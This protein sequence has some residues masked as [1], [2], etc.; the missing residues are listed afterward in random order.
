MID[1]GLPLKQLFESK[2]FMYEFDYDEWPSTHT[3][4]NNVLR[5]YHYSLLQVRQNYRNVFPEPEYKDEDLNE[6]QDSSKIF[7]IKYTINILPCFGSHIKL[8]KNRQH[9][10]HV[11]DDVDFM[12]ILGESDDMEIFSL[13]SIKTLNEFKWRE[14]ARRNF[15]F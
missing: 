10:K 7:K 9:Q 3:Y 11:N 14:Q 15:V 5:P 6:V 8:S 4:P 13:E 2:V 1:Y 12:Y